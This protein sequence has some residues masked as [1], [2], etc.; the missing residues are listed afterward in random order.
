MLQIIFFLRTNKF[1]V[2][3]ASNQVIRYYFY[4]IVIFYF[5]IS[6]CELLICQ[7]AV[8]FFIMNLCKT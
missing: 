6:S 1:F 3:L 8:I 5:N 7:S 2:N 4:Y